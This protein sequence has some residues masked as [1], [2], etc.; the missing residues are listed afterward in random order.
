MLMNLKRGKGRTLLMEH[1]DV[2][3]NGSSSFVSHFISGKYVSGRR[4]VTRHC[5][6]PN[7]LP[8]GSFPSCLLRSG[9]DLRVSLA[10]L[11]LK[12]KNRQCDFALCLPVMIVRTIAGVDM[13]K[14]LERSW[15][16]CLSCPSLTFYVPSPSDQHPQA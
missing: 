13:A 2:W 7:L 15:N 4:D 8:G 5:A 11:L 1:S 3:T 10:K 16:V 14:D 12:N 9:Q 6:P